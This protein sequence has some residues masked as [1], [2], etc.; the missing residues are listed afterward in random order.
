MNVGVTT[1]IGSCDRGSEYLGY[2]HID[3]YRGF[4]ID[5]FLAQ[6]E[7]LVY[8]E[9]FDVS[10]DGS[11]QWLSPS[12]SNMLLIGQGIATVGIEDREWAD[13]DTA[14]SEAASGGL[15]D[16]TRED[17]EG[18]QTPAD[19]GELA[20]NSDTTS[21]NLGQGLELDAALSNAFFASLTK[22]Q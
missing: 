2:L 15:D 20:T 21:A 6:W 12:A 5:E 9:A 3:F 22:D 14:S 8:G 17:G 7:V 19:G 11:K 1:F 10:D 13:L 18:P 16:T 4:P